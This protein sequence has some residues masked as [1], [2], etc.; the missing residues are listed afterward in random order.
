MRRYGTSFAKGSGTFAKMLG[1]HAVGALLPVLMILFTILAAGCGETAVRQAPSAPGQRE[2]D[3]ETALAH[4]R[5]GDASPAAKQ[6]VELTLPHM[7][8]PYTWGGNG[9]AEFDCSGLV[10][11]VFEG[12]GI[13]LPRV[14]YDQVKCGRPVPR[15][16]LK[17]GDLV[18]FDNNGHVGIYV[19]DG[20]MLHAFPPDVGACSIDDHENSHGEVSGCRRLL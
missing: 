4:M 2:P 18:F 10:K 19:D 16:A 12:V 15:D 20:I 8:K 13:E 7:G 17:T 5:A 9:P 3:L 6:V 14:T 1:R 11:Y